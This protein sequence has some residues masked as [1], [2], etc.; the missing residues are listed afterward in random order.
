MFPPDMSVLPHDGFEEDFFEC[1]RHD[2]DR[3]W[4]KRLSFGDDAVRIGAADDAHHAALACDALD[5]GRPE[6]C[7]RS[8]ARKG[9]ADA[10]PGLAQVVQRPAYNQSALVDDRDA[11]GYLVDF[12]ELVG[13]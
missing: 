12:G 7:H 4:R 5:A 13:G 6:I 8:I 2:L 3:G 11:V 10:P 9:Q 1:D